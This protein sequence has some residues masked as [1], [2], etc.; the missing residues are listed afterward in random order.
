MLRN[1]KTFY[2]VP[3]IRHRRQTLQ[4]Y[5][6]G[7]QVMGRFKWGKKW[8]HGRVAT[9]HYTQGLY[10]IQYNDGDFESN[11]DPDRLRKIVDEEEE[12]E[13]EEEE[14]DIEIPDIYATDDKK[15]CNEAIVQACRK[16]LTWS[17]I[18]ALVIDAGMLNTTTCLVDG[19]IISHPC[20]KVDIVNRDKKELPTM[21]ENMYDLQKKCA[22][23][24]SLHTI[25]S[26]DY[27]TR[28]S[29]RLNLVFLDYT[30]TLGTIRQSGDIEK[31]F[32]GDD[33]WMEGTGVFAVTFCLR[34]NKTRDEEA[35]EIKTYLDTVVL[36]KYALKEEC[37]KRYGS[38][39]HMIFLLF[40]VE[41]VV[42]TT[43]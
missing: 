14:I 19:N 40:S 12:E 5:E 13:V 9:V 36:G 26:S 16:Y 22:G 38:S 31:L 7:E 11:V 1:N 34:G 15:D 3:K 25:D 18:Q 30:Q 20:D 43:N 21:V 37:I 39:R 6:V 2:K 28:F 27:L 32:G 33:F 29:D 10:D 4:R 41:K 24:L 23:L 42:A 35:E 8:Y 17:Y